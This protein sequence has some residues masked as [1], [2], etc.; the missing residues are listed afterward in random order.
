MIQFPRARLVALLLVLATAAPAAAATSVV[1]VRHA[2]KAAEPAVDP[3]LTQAGEARARAL[4]DALA[5]AR[6]TAI[7][8]TPYE[9]TRRTAAPLAERAGVAPTVVEVG[10]VAT[11]AADI[12]RRVREDA[13]D[14]TIVVVGHSNTLPAV[15]AALGVADV[16][17][18]A[19]DEYD[20]MLI[21][22]LRDGAAP[23]LV[24]SRYGPAGSR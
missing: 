5:R 16:A 10:D 3:P 1:L 2:E 6:V 14:G 7:L 4:A 17:P 19:D 12:A 18:I 21:V 24:Q 8:S 13:S 11:H 15:A 20:R 9:R 22:V 23:L